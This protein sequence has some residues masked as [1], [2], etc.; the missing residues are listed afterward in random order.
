[1]IINQH[2]IAL[3]FSRV[4]NN[5]PSILPLF[6]TNFFWLSQQD[7]KKI[8]KNFEQKTRGK[9]VGIPTLNIA[10]PPCG[11]FLMSHQTLQG[12]GVGE[13]GRQTRWGGGC[14]RPGLPVEGN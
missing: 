3:N 6:L 11:A 7:P 14:C 2:A 5:N 9:V 1:M 12:V 13:G 10:V 8:P 4:G